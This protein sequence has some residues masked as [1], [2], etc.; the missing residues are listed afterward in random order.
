MGRVEVVRWLAKTT[1]KTSSKIFS[2]MVRNPPTLILT[3]FLFSFDALFFLLAAKVFF[4]PFVPGAS[5][6]ETAASKK[7]VISLPF[8]K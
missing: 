2:S 5:S 6:F 7:Y 1:A 4:Q 8:S 3:S